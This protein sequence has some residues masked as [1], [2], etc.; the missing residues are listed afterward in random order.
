MEIQHKKFRDIHILF[1]SG[2]LDLYNATSLEKLFTNLIKKEVKNIILDFENINYIDSSGIGVLLKLKSLSSESSV[3]FSLSNVTGEVLN[4]LKLTNLIQ[5][6]EIA[7]NYET[8]IR[9]AIN[10]A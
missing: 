4:V 7:D 9:K 1:L 3:L 8:A 2:E 10:G 6:F 5:F